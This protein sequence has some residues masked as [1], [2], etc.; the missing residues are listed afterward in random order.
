MNNNTLAILRACLVSLLLP[1]TAAMAADAVPPAG[2]SLAFEELWEP[3]T[4]A[5]GVLGV[6]STHALKQ[7]P[8]KSDPEQAWASS[9]DM[10]STSTSD[11][12]ISC[13]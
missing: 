12:A 1:F 6:V 9:T 13:A 2:L 3:R 5:T 10:H 7:T 8:D 4:A 11:A